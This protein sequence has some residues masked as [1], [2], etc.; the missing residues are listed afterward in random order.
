MA[1]AQDDQRQAYPLPVYNYRVTIDD[2]IMSFSEVSGI[3]TEYDVVTYRHGLS[4]LEGERIESFR[5][6]SFI[7][8][9]FARGIALGA[10]PRFLEK[11]MAE[12]AS[13]PI[14]ISLCDESGAA[15]L[16]WKIAIAVPFRLKA[17]SFEA[18]SNDVAIERLDVKARGIS[19][20]EP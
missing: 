13:R 1:E 4:F 14:D 2:R 10:S 9:T 17:P 8:V 20:T 5:F 6:D 3:T 12:K 16:S 18:N 11:W 7:D 19:L 15:V